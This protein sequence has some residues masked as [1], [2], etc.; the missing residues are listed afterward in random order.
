[1][2]KQQYY[3][4][5]G[6]A[7][8]TQ[9]AAAVNYLY[10]LAGNVRANALEGVPSVYLHRDPRGQ[11]SHLSDDL[12]AYFDYC[13]MGNIQ[14]G[15]V[16]AGGSLYEPFLSTGKYAVGLE[17]AGMAGIL[18]DEGGGH[19][20]PHNAQLDLQN[21][22]SAPSLKNKTPTAGPPTVSGGGGGNGDDDDPNDPWW[23]RLFKQLGRWFRGGMKSP[24]LLIRIFQ[25]KQGQFRVGRFDFYWGLQGR[26]G[27]WGTKLQGEFPAQSHGHAGG[28]WGRFDWFR[29]WKDKKNTWYRNRGPDFWTW[30][31]R[32]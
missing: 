14:E 11:I 27:L 9:G 8:E 7:R 29:P 1:V 19:F 16:A 24:W 3:D 22:P 26:I 25:D 18:Y 17:G 10:D 21:N 15:G 23:K 2:P 30:L 28:Q 13:F 31:K 32:Q 6:M 12:L 5:L 4:L 20:R